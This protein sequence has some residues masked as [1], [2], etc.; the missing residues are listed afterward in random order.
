[1]PSSKRKTRR[2]EVDPI[3]DHEL[4]DSSPSKP[5]A[6][7][8]KVRSSVIDCPK[9]DHA[10]PRQTNGAKASPVRRVKTPEPIPQHIDTD[11]DESIEEEAANNNELIESVISY[12]GIAKDPVA[13][14]YQ[15][16]NDNTSQAGSKV[17]AYAKIAGRD[18]TYFVRD[19]VINIGRPPDTR[20]PTAL[21]SSPGPDAKDMPPVHIDLGPN[22]IVSRHHA[23]IFYDSDYPEGGAWHVRVNGRNGIRLNTVLLKRAQTS[24]LKCGD[25]V[26]IA[27][28]QMMFVTPG[29]VAEIHQDFKERAARLADEPI[30]STHAHPES[31]RKPL[32][33]G[34]TLHPTN[35]GQQPLAP[36]PPNHKRAATPPPKN[37][38]NLPSQSPMYNR[39]MMM[40]STQEIDYSLD[41]AKDLKPPFSYASMIA[42]AIFSSDEEKLTLSNIYQWIQD[43]YAFYRHSNTGWQVSRSLFFVESIPQLTVSPELYPAQPVSEQSFPESPSQN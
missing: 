31:I 16:A 13:V 12:L 25:V 39:G 28:T 20:D 27:G 32:L 18:W 40:E 41:S 30:I 38:L 26:E 7:K 1:M 23:S 21:A 24:Q 8:R 3:S 34:P 14:Q 17:N 9:Q 11:E 36:A 37:E 5:S 4:P 35:G 42:Q 33:N 19:Q 10:D 15:H 29:D 6:K 22:K 2:R 43:R